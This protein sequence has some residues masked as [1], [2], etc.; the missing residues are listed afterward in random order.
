VNL[1]H[2]GV[3]TTLFAYGAVS[4]GRQRATLAA[5]APLATERAGGYFA[6]W[7]GIFPGSAEIDCSPRARGVLIAQFD[8]LDEPIV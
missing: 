5:S 2:E 7:Q 6:R 1:A 3:L 8:L 4:E